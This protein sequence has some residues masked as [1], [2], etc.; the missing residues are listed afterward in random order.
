MMGKLHVWMGDHRKDGS[1]KLRVGGLVSIEDLENKT[2]RPSPSKSVRKVCMS[3]PNSRGRIQILRLG[4]RPFRVFWLISL[5][6]GTSI[7]FGTKVPLD[8]ATR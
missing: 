6:E 5:P 4:P 3:Q 1:E 7:S 8:T 2:N